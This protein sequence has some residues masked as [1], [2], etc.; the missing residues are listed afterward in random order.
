MKALDVDTADQLTIGLFNRKSNLSQKM[1]PLAYR[2]IF[3]PN[4]IDVEQV[5]IGG[6]D[7]AQKE[8][9]LWRRIDAALESPKTIAELADALDAKKDSIEKALKA[10]PDKFERAPQSEDRVTRWQRVS[11]RSNRFVA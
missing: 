1:L 8:L 11:V 7:G 4:A 3:S 9:P 5:P 10:R 6:L 2:F